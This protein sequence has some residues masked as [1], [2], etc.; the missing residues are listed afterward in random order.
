MPD[1]WDSLNQKN[2]DRALNVYSKWTTHPIRTTSFWVGSIVAFFVALSL[3][4][5]LF[6]VAN[7]YWQAEQSKLTLKPRLTIYSNST[8]NAVAQKAFFTSTCNDVRAAYSNW[9]IAEQNV[10]TLEANIKSGVV[11]DPTGATMEQTQSIAQ[12]LE[13]AVPTAAAAY[14][15]RAANSTANQYIPSGYPKSINVP[16]NLVGWTPPACG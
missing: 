1:D 8:G 3:I 14:N 15:A 11:Q 9:Q 10:I 7:I 16:A 13:T 6:G 5:N 4:G 2:A 12:G